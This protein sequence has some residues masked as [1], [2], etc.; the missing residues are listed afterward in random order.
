V[1][2]A[3]FRSLFLFAASAGW[4]AAQAPPRVVALTPAAMSEVDAKTT[5]QLVVEFD[6]AM[7]PNGI[8]LCGG[9]PSYPNAKGRPQWKNPKTLVIDVELAPD[10]A[11]SLGIN[12]PAASGFR[13]S[14]GV[15]V[16]PVPWTFFTLPTKLPPAGEQKQRNQKAAA[17]LTKVLA[18]S[19]S[20]RD[21]RIK[22][23]KKLEK[24]HVPAL[25]AAKTDRGFAGAAAAML[26]ATEDIHLYLR[27]GE[28]TFPT[29]TR[30]VDS[31]YGREAIDR[32]AKVEAIGEQA[33]VGRTDDGI[34]Y[35]MIGA[36]T[37]AIDPER[38]GMAIT[39]L[40][41]TK[42]MVIDVRPNSGGD[43]L[44]A[45]KV[46]AWFIS[47][48]KTYAKNRYRVRAGK[49]GFGPVI[50][51]Q[52]TGH[53][54][55]K[56]YDQP[57]AVLTSR[58]IMSSNESFVMMLRQAKDCTVIG[59]PTYGSSANPKPFELGNGV[60]IVV[61][62]WQDLRLDGSPFEGEG[63]APDVLVPCTMQDFEQKDPIL[64]QALATLRSK[65]K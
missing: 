50:D 45:Q 39:S 21:L 7:D 59:Q 57:I 9:G 19:Y 61:P 34:G 41:D 62:T 53:G 14:D 3:C 54:K 20:H 29:G 65:T 28:T 33:L 36:W 55:G 31:L 2:I 58:N 35:L 44:L 32:Y 60:T 16:V 42:A 40:L 25:L 52:I 37:N 46:A 56:L 17:E 1:R 18:E 23:W 27:C 8:S 5:T 15:T 30:A 24:Q 13:S 6:R 51:R 11:Y 63:L 12:C 64:E 38:I 26:R 47:G 43:E 48:T 4:L 22:D 49:D 10:H